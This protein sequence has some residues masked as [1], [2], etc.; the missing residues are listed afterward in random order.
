MGDCRFDGDRE[1]EM[2]ITF[3]AERLKARRL[4]VADQPL[5]LRTQRAVQGKEILSTGQPLEI[6]DWQLP[7]AH[8]GSQP[9]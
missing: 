6:V 2:R 9:R 7:V 1:D 4:T 5:P 8:T 3:H